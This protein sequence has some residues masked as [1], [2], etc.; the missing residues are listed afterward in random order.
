MEVRGFLLAWAVASAVVAA[1]SLG[2]SFAHVLEA[3]PRLRWSP[4]L[5]RAT[6]VFNG[7]YRL[8][9]AVGAPLD[10]AAIVLPAALSWMARGDRPATWQALA[11]AALFACALLAWFVL[12]RPANAAMAGWAPGPLPADFEAV[13]SRW[14][15]GHA[16]V[17][18]IKTVGF[19]SLVLALLS[20]GRG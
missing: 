12:V 3:V 17:A 15:T 16:V 1:L 11:A 13:R 4:E 8:F 18:A 10:I 2:P 20:L 9:A 14:E 19:A 7:Q 5:W 6:T